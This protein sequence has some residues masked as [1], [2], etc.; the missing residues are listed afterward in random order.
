MAHVNRKQYWIIFLILGAL[1]ALEVG[2]VYIPGI[3]RPLLVVALVSLAVTKAVIVGL[4]YM[5]LSHETKGL[6]LTVAVPVVAPAIYA[7]ALITE[8]TWRLLW[9]QS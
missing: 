3:A 2:V 5:H 4:Y 7:F 8:A 9:A 6:K 1:T